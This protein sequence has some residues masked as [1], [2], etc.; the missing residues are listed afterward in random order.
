MPIAATLI[1][2][3][4][5]ALMAGPVSKLLDAYVHDQELRRKLAAELQ[6]QLVDNL[7]KSLALEQSIVL[8]EIQSDNWLTKAW[9]PLL[10]LSL[11]G[12][13]GFV[14]VILPLADLIAGHPLPFNPRW[15]ALPAGL[16]VYVRSGFV[17]TISGRFIDEM[18]HAVEQGPPWLNDIGIG[19][20]GGQVAREQGDL[21][22]AI[23]Q[24]RTILTAH[25]PEMGTRGL[26]FSL[27]YEV[28]N[29]LGLALTERAAQLRGATPE[30]REARTRTLQEAA[31]AFER[32]L[33]IDPEN[34]TA[35]YTV[36]QVYRSLGDEARAATHRTLHLRYKPDENARD[37]AVAIAR[38][39]S[40]AADHASQPVVIYPLHPPSSP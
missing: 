39:A 30:E 21:P 22:W 20:L 31:D 7:G 5:N 8:A 9:R 6:T 13:L 32:T 12:F 14:G 40:A 29:A 10:M 17:Q 15:Q 35:H 36:A 16:G 11:L 24:Y 37:R 2:N 25:T 34:V 33:T 18:I 1:F 38:R 23:D 26:D 28:W 27:D 19:P 3:A 4:V